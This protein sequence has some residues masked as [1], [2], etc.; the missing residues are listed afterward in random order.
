MFCKICLN[1]K[2]E[3]QH[4]PAERCSGRLYNWLNELRCNEKRWHLSRLTSPWSRPVYFRQAVQGDISVIHNLEIIHTDA[5]EV[6]SVIKG[7]FEACFRFNSP[8]ARILK[9]IGVLR[10]CS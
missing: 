6:G 10:A 8:A 2:K 9:A 7:I 1:D 4:C 5:N 3:S